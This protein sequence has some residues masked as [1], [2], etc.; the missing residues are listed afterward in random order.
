MWNLD[1][2]NKFEKFKRIWKEF[3]LFDLE[4]N[5][6]DWWEYNKTEIIEI[7]AVRLDNNFNVIK[8]Y[9]VYIRPTINPILTPFIQDLTKITQEKIDSVWVEFEEWVKL[10]QE[11]KD[12]IFVSFWKYDIRQLWADWIKNF[13]PGLYESNKENP[14]KFKEDLYEYIQNP[15][16]EFYEQTKNHV[17]I[18]DVFRKKLW[19]KRPKWMKWLL[20]YLQIPLDW[21]HHNWFDDV[22]NMVKI[23]HHIEENYN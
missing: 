7:W 21:T 14:S 19:L 12:A 10:F 15:L 17:N 11:N 4:A 8:K 9:D 18:K 2:E 13:H 5:S 1:K 3:L 20:D 16:Y 6:D 22:M 23:L